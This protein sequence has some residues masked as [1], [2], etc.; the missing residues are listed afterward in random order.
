VGPEGTRYVL[1][2]NPDFAEP[3]PFNRLTMIFEHEITHI[4]LHHFSRGMQM[5]NMVE[6]E[7]ALRYFMLAKPLAA[8]MAVNEFVRRNH[9]PHVLQPPRPEGMSDKEFAASPQYSQAILAED[10]KLP[11]NLSYEEYMRLLLEMMKKEIPE[12]EKIIKEV[13]DELKDLIEAAGGMDPSSILQR[14][15]DGI[16]EKLGDSDDGDGDSD[17]G[18]G[19]S[20]DGDGEGSQSSDDGDD[21]AAKLRNRIKQDLLKAVMDHLQEYI[22]D[23]SDPARGAHVDAHGKAIIRAATQQYKQ[24]GRGT[25]PGYL[26][27]IIA[28]LLRPPT[29]SW[30]EI[31]HNYVVNALR[32]RP[33]RGNTRVSNNKAAMVMALKRSAEKLPTLENFRRLAIAKRTPL[34]PGTERDKRFTIV[35]VRDTSGSMSTDD[36][37]EGLAELLHIQKSWPDIELI[38]LDVDAAVCCETRLGPT[39]PIDYS[40]VG[41][42]GTDFEPAFQYIQDNVAHCDL[43]V[44]MTDGYAPPPTTMIPCMT[45]W[46]LTA[47]GRSVMEGVAGHIT[48]QMRPYQTQAA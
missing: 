32:G 15:L 19:D 16:D 41:R 10:Y 3:Q 7:K 8:D 27:E 23:A 44:Y 17:D 34:F 5:Y 39:T 31:L 6:S 46:L 14:A 18:D 28:Q 45:I 37:A 22:S 43:V 29:V 42:G 40:L 26:E 11:P 35:V 25:L 38:L 20:D 13:V 36:L 1:F 4:L 48:I 12:P 2:M 47:T 24:S 30:T 33:K 21:A 9:L